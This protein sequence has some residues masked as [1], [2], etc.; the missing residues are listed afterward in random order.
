MGGLGGEGHHVVLVPYLGQGQLGLTGVVGVQPLKDKQVTG[1]GA[2][3]ASDVLV[4]V[5]VPILL[6]GIQSALHH[7]NAVGLQGLAGADED[8]DGVACD[9]SGANPENAAD[10]PAADARGAAYQGHDGGKEQGDDDACDHHAH[11]KGR[12]ALV[13][14]LQIP[15][16]QL[17]GQ[18]V[19][20]AFVVTVRRYPP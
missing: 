7:L 14:L 2:G 5:G 16:D 18:A 9:H 1:N 13:P 3:L 11:G 20:A 17:I 4:S 12:R 10:D 6:N 19:S 15:Q 8:G